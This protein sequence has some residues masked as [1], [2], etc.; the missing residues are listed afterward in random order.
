M[1]FSQFDYGEVILNAL[2]GLML[3]VGKDNS[4]ICNA[5]TFNI[6]Q[7]LSLHEFKK[8]TAAELL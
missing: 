1:H 2:S 6:F 5:N 8:V 3:T 4:V 7:A